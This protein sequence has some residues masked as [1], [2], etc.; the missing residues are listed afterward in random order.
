[1][2][3]VRRL[4]SGRISLRQLEATWNSRLQDLL[5][6]VLSRHLLQKCNILFAIS[7]DRIL[8]LVCIVDISKVDI[9]PRLEAALPDSFAVR[10]KVLSRL[11]LEFCSREYHKD[12]KED[13]ISLLAV[14]SEHIAPSL[15]AVIKQN[16]GK[17]LEH[18]IEAKSLIT[19]RLLPVGYEG[20]VLADNESQDLRIIF[21]R[22]SKPDISLY[23]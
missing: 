10:N 13:A 18:C 8:R 19:C 2:L 12:L 7:S 16:L 5:W 4:C 17:W 6:I 21:D 11:I 20:I 15:H 22:N 1:M 9:S 3:A 14:H 23:L